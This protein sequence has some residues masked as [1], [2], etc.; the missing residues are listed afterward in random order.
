LANEVARLFT[1]HADEIRVYLFRRL[2]DRSVAA[3]MV[4]DL[5]LRVTE[6]PNIAGMENTRAYLYRMAA[7]LAIDHERRVGRRAGV[8]AAVD[9]LPDAIDDRPSP[10]AIAEG[11][12]RLARVNTAIA[13]LPELTQEIFRRNRLEGISYAEVADQLSISESSVQKHL[14][15]ALAHALAAIDG[16]SELAV[17]D[18][19]ADNVLSLRAA[20]KVR[21][22]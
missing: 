7:N 4:Q 10:E 11:K 12:D 5:F 18:L 22:R 19:P 14:A 8:W 6:K 13:A 16:Q 21:R 9:E 20:S 3:D 17:T 15:R 2:G 1:S